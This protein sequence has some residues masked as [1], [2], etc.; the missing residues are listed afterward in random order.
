MATFK[1]IVITKTESATAA[2]L[3]DFNEQDLMEGDVTVI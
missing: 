3:T 1:A 2:A